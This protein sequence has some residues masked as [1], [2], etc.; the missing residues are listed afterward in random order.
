MKDTPPDA[1][2]MDFEAYDGDEPLWEEEQSEEQPYRIESLDDPNIHDEVER[3]ATDIVSE[4]NRERGYTASQEDF[5]QEIQDE[6]QRLLQEHIAD[7]YKV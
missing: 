3:I 2:P 6:K 7:Y 1:D 4:R 5:D